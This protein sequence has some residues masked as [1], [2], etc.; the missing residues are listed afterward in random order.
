MLS[1]GSNTNFT[2]SFMTPSGS[3]YENR[4]LDSDVIDLLTKI[5]L[6][7]IYNSNGTAEHE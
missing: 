4:T 6:G 3:I 1:R 7:S 2:D 5:V